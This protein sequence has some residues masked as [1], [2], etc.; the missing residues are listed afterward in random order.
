[1][2]ILAGDRRRGALGGRPPA[3]K[4]GKLFAYLL[5][6]GEDNCAQGIKALSQYHKEYDE[7]HA[8]YRDNPSHDWASHGAD[9][10]RYLCQALA[11]GK[12]PGTSTMHE[13]VEEIRQL[14]LQYGRPA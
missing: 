14:E 12:R 6:V 2:L 9:A 3:F 1:M 4:G 5:A 7:T 13:T 11:K 8:C 10:F